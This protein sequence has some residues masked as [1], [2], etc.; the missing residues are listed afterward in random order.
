MRGRTTVGLLLRY[1]SVTSLKRRGAIFSALSRVFTAP[2]GHKPS[3]SALL[4][5]VTST[6]ITTLSLMPQETHTV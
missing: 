4:F 2:T 5:I 6:H 1:I 3:S